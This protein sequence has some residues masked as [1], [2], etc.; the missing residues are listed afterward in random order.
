MPRL[1]WYATQPEQFHLA[2]TD[3]SVQQGVPWIIQKVINFAS[4][5]LI[6][7]QQPPAHPET[8]ATVININQ[9]VRPGGF[10]SANSYVLDGDTRE[11]TVP[12]FGAMSMRAA[13]ANA[14]DVTEDDALGRNVERPISGDE[15]IGIRE[16]AKGVHTG[17]STTSLW[18]FEKVDGERRFCKYCITTKEDQKAQ[19][20]LVYDYKPLEI[21]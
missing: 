5:E 20:R 21:E 6:M 13:Y 2:S 15:R 18:A 3:I 4:L 19:A 12:I 11:D 17:W 1:P 8:P 14:A 9:I 16:V 7:R 10:D